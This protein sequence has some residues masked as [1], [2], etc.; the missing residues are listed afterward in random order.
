[1]WR[2][3]VRQ[4]RRFEQQ[5]RPTRLQGAPVDFGHLV[6]HGYRFTNANQ[7]AV[8]LKIRHEAAQIAE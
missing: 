7:L 4:N 1:L 8:L 2:G 6:H 5:R 3:A